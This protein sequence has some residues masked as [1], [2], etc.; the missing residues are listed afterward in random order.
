MQ[1]MSVLLVSPSGKRDPEVGLLYLI[2]RFLISQGHHVAQLMCNGVVAGCDRD[3]D[4][5]WRRG[6]QSCLGCMQEQRDLAQWGGIP[7]LRL[8][9]GIIAEVVQHSSR[10]IDSLPTEELW[11]AAVGGIGLAELAQA[12]FEARFGVASPDFNNKL[13]DRFVRMLLAA[14]LRVHHGATALLKSRN[15]SL[16][17][18]PANAGLITAT[19]GKAALTLKIPVFHWQAQL[20]KRCITIHAAHSDML[21]ECPLL[22][23]DVLTLRTDMKTWSPDLVSILKATE[24]FLG[25]ACVVSEKSVG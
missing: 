13:H 18:L 4:S 16:L 21:H 14:V 11:G 20:A 2:G 24:E 1:L 23:E 3:A 9:E 25:L 10:W 17:L 19:V 15:P 12:T 7:A 5:N 8:S 22:I 6:I